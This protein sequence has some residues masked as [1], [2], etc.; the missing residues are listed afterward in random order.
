MVAAPGGISPRPP[1]IMRV[2]I[3]ASALLLLARP[4]LADD[5]L[6]AQS[7]DVYAQVP[8]SVSTS[9]VLNQEAA[10]DFDVVGLVRRVRIGGGLC[11]NCTSPDVKGV[12]V[13]FWSWDQGEVGTLLAEH[14]L[15]ADD[16]G[17]GYDP[18]AT[19]VL[20]VTLPTP[21]AADGKHFVSAQLDVEGFS[22][23]YWWTGGGGQPELSSLR[24][25]DNLAGGGFAPYE[26]ITGVLER[27]L[28]FELWGDGQAAPPTVPEL[29]WAQYKG[30]LTPS[31]P[32][33]V[34]PG[35]AQA[36]E[37]ADDFD[38][39]GDVH[40][41]VVNWSNCYQ[42]PYPVFTSARVRFYEWTASGPGALLYEADVPAGPGQAVF[43]SLLLTVFLP[44]PFA[45]TGQHYVSVQ[46]QT[47]APNGYQWDT[48]GDEPEALSAAWVRDENGANAWVPAEQG[49]TPITGDL[50]FA[51]WGV[52]APAPPPVAVGDPCGPWKPLPVPTHP[53]TTHS[54]LR[55]VKVFA[56]DDVWA[57][58]TL[59]RQV[60]ALPNDTISGTVSK[61][62]D[63]KTW[64]EV[65]T[66]SPEPYAGAGGAGL[67][68]V[69]GVA[70]DDL[71]AAG[72][73]QKQGAG[74]FIG[75]QILVMHWDGSSWT[76]VPS[77]I[78][79]GEQ[80]TL[81]GSSGGFVRGIEAIA[82]D[83]VWF[84][85][86]W[87]EPFGCDEALAMRWEGSD[88]VRYPT[89]CSG[90][91][92]ANG[93]FSLEAV[94]AVASDDV[95]AVGGSQSGFGIH[96]YAIHWDGSSWSHVPTPEKGYVQ[97]LYD[98]EA[99]AA[100]DVWA[101]GQFLDALGYHAF[102]LH[103]DG[104]GWTDVPIPGGSLGLWASASDDVYAVG[105]G[106]F[107]WDGSTWAF[108]DDLGLLSGE[109]IGVS[110]AAIDGDGACSV[111]AVG[112]HV[113][114]GTML[115]YAARVVLPTFWDATI[116]EG[117]T[118]P[119]LGGGLILADPPALGSTA[120]VLVDDPDG[121]AG[122]TAGASAALWAVS[123]SGG[124]GFPCG[125]PVPGFGPLGAPAG[126]ALIGLEGAW[127]FVHTGG[128]WQGPGA[129]LDAELSVPADPSLTGL[130]LFTQAVLVDPIGPAGVVVTNALD[131][132]IGS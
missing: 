47:T 4:T 53:N 1:S 128:V 75:T 116:R 97:Q 16:P 106:V 5:L 115:P 81:Q 36:P 17:L 51:L 57:V 90:L 125:V 72:S 61:H 40:R 117:C 109:G 64:S 131:L 130:E 110:L 101:V 23:W 30:F 7:V 112:R 28:A 19:S 39:D 71:W 62:F 45:A 15:A 73:Q 22:S 32:A 123:S 3:L 88:F 56:A 29:V 31:V 126:E 80:G 13:R 24:W 79:P 6:W 26:P 78:T 99:I 65:P 96:G 12:W 18:L 8:S 27:D 100:D 42:C 121:V 129:P 83:D 118:A 54:V 86:N 102:A 2:L 44:Q 11:F 69:D 60:G 74:L 9:P 20:D 89:P 93:G 92:G 59:T 37:L 104:T 98:V 55:D 113:P 66:P 33:S 105:G 82:T 132:R 114:L 94:S 103:W 49:P 85:G 120:R 70:P 77:P 87:V 67:W 52:P 34:W 58:G 25:R 76:V 91:P 111:H 41:V 122:L 46:A 14:Y 63:G 38:F 119:T 108:V 43:E 50:G 48:T 107:R 84:V 95:W 35:A 10:D 124:P 127:F 21:F 68:A